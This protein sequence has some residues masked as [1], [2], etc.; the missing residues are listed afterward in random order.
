[1]TN[2][3]SDD[4]P[5]AIAVEKAR[6]I[7]KLGALAVAH[8]TAFQDGITPYRV[9]DQQYRA[10]IRCFDANL[11]GLLE[12]RLDIV[13]Q[14]RLAPFV[15]SL[16]RTGRGRFNCR[17]GGR[18]DIQPYQGPVP[19]ATVGELDEAGFLSVAA[20][21]YAFHRGS[22]LRPPVDWHALYKLYI[23]T[24]ERELKLT[25]G[26]AYGRVC[27]RVMSRRIE[28]VP[29]HWRATF[30]VPYDRAPRSADVPLAFR[31][32]KATAA[33][34]MAI[35]SEEGFGVLLHPD[36][37]QTVGNAIAPIRYERFRN[38]YEGPCPE[39]PPDCQ[40]LSGAHVVLTA[41]LAFYKSLPAPPLRPS[42]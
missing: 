33:N 21:C 35:Q 20:R 7:E 2:L 27:R 4:L 25:S 10:I 34:P 38:G 26:L 16:T 6:L 31:I 13:D 32:Y 40:D 28:G 23:G 39:L 18:A 29:E 19:Q 41:C 30:V 36:P 14:H 1:M 3:P 9:I 17:I 42:R 5:A 22:A 15:I 8:G 12:F 37:H 11:Q 24:L